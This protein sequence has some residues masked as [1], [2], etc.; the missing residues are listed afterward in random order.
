VTG[1]ETLEESEII[2]YQELISEDAETRADYCRLFDGRARAF[3]AAMANLT[4]R[5]TQ[6]VE[7]AFPVE[8]REKAGFITRGPSV[9]AV[10]H[11]SR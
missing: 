2:I 10:R 6:A 5:R 11:P 7:L 3:S 1:V 4:C 8:A 9:L